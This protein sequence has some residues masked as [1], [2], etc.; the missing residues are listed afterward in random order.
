MKGIS[1]HILF[2]A[3]DLSTLVVDLTVKNILRQGFLNDTAEAV[4]KVLHPVALT[5]VS[6][7]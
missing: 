4:T 5:V 7:S 3:V 6:E 1:I 2:L